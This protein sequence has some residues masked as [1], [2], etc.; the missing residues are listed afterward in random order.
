MSDD[1]ELD[2]TEHEVKSNV[3]SLLLSQK[4]AIQFIESDLFK[5]VQTMA[6]Q[7]LSFIR[8]IDWKA[9]HAMYEGIT[10]GLDEF[11]K[12]I[13]D[14]SNAMA[15]DG[16]FLNLDYYGKILLGEDEEHLDKESVERWMEQSLEETVGKISSL[17]FM[18]RHQTVL[19]QTYNA[20]NSGDYAL[21]IMGVYPVIEYFV[22]NWTESQRNGGE[23]DH[24]KPTR[25]P[26][27]KH[28][29]KTIADGYCGEDVSFGDIERYFEM[30]AL[31]GF[32]ELF[33]YKSSS[34]LARNPILHGSHDYDALQKTD[35]LKLIYLLNT[36]VGLYGVLLDESN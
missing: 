33:N 31:E 25:K 23:F 9:V 30:K 12:G 4:L 17:D 2:K 14:F 21:A 6:G 13:I 11:R 35:Y 10:K 8:S 3:N 34:R 5:N 28:E 20:Y 1:K 19:N 15:K 26:L 36:L 27:K 32:H 22:A 16:Y 24:E 29:V 18:A 7:V